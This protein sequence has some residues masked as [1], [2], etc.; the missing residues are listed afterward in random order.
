MR[1]AWGAVSSLSLR[2]KWALLLV[3]LGVIPLAVSAALVL[4]IQ[5]AGLLRAEQ[6]LEVAVVDEA[7]RSLEG[8]IADASLATRRV[9]EVLSDGRIADDDLRVSLARERVGEAPDLRAA[10]IYGADGALI[11]VIVRGED[12]VAPPGPLG[13]ERP[14][15]PARVVCAGTADAPP[16]LRCVAAMVADGQVRGWV[17]GLLDV[18]RLSSAISELSRTRFGS[19]GRVAIVDEGERVVLG[20][21]A[22]AGD[23]MDVR[24]MLGRTQLSPGLFASPFAM[25]LE[26]EDATGARRVG[27]LTSIPARRWAVVVQRPEAE[28]FD[29][30]A[31]SRRAFLAAAGALVLIALVAGG[32][33][34]RRATRPVAELVRLTE[35]YGRRDFAARSSVHT[36][37]EL[38]TL[39]TSLTRMADSLQASEAEIQRRAT[40]ESGL[41]RYL[42][43]HL[44]RAIARGESSLDLGGK[45]REVTVVFADVASFTPFAEGAAPEEAAAFLNELF[46]MLSEIVF[47]HGGMVDKFIGDCIM[48]IFGV[49]DDAGRHCAAAVAAAEDMNRFV[50]ASAEAWRE[51]WNLDV[52]LGIG[53]ASGPA[54]VGNLGS[55]ERMEHTA[56]GDVVNV[57][58][59]LETLARPGQTLVTAAVVQGAGAAFAFSTLGEQPIRGKSSRVEVFELSS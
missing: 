6:E 25:T 52:R 31:A 47:R 9:A 33:L 29:A 57:A 23:A 59:R 24:R 22:G 3:A 43:A 1:Y 21:P 8:T 32:L 18:A 54:L 55:R 58:A 19:D 30:L 26:F 41:A 42:P 48:A 50:E 36:G 7:T 28:A 2:T 12:R 53:I 16:R 38:E 20:A 14:G 37:D 15:D 11:D 10:A 45:R 35:A 46:T 27:T 51:R 5:R 17:V 44:A 4:R 34:A 49:I 56:I 13:D 40:V 39:G